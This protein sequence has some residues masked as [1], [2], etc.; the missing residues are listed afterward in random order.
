MKEQILK[1]TPQELKYQKPT[2]IIECYIKLDKYGMT[3]Y[4][5]F[6]ADQPKDHEDE[7]LG[8]E[9]VLQHFETFALRSQITGVERGWNTKEHRWGLYVGIKGFDQDIRAFYKSESKSLEHFNII[10]NWI[11]KKPWYVRLLNY[12]YIKL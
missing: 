3:W 6:F 10:K 5:K 1:S 8:T 4:C 9:N 11:I 7:S 2:E 12:F